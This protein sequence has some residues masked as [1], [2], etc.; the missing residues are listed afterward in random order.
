MAHEMIIKLHGLVSA[1]YGPQRA[2]TLDY[3]NKNADD[4]KTNEE[5]C[6]A[7]RICSQLYPEDKEHAAQILSKIEKSPSEQPQV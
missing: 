5:M 7:L 4:W 6:R 3:L 1:L 2:K